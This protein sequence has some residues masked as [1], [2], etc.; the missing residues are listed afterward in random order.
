MRRI[1]I[2]AYAQM[3]YMQ[4]RNSSREVMIHEVAH[5]ALKMAAISKGD[6]DTVI[7]AQNDYLDGRTISNMKTVAASG[8]YFKD[9]SKIEMDGA[10]A[11]F[12]A[13]MRILTGNHDVAMVIGE[14]MASCY[15]PYLPGIWSLDP[16]FD[17]PN[18]FL[19][20]I[21]A[22]ALQ[23]RAY[24]HKYGITERQIAKVAV[25]N[26]KNADR[27][28]CA[29]RKMPRI[30]ENAVLN[31][32]LLYEPIRELNAYPLTDGACAIILAVESKARQIT[33]KPVWITGAG[34][35]HDTYFLGERELYGCASLERAAETAY[36]MSGITN[37]QKEIQVW[38]LHENFSH[39][40]LIFYEALG[41]CEKG[42]GGQLIDSKRTE[43]NGPMPVNP[44][45]GA[46]SANPVYATGLIRLCEVA[47]QIRGEAGEHQ[48]KREVKTGLAH[49]QN[50]LCAQDNIVFT[51]KGE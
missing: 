14:S 9:E 17:R 45:G 34:C 46:L 51:L 6:V 27:N 32:K 35:C 4:N 30:S 25:K 10:F 36:K 8:A 28:P 2:V 50:G 22:A 42:K 26:L 1:A 19:N 13:Y 11:A 7:N 23:A 12:Y 44:S 20:E 29:V 24:M 21:S 43:P 40:E 3:K 39:E 5:E 18:G 38:E 49:G 47:M 31:S 37:P 41:M 16:T 33:N 48:V 15:P